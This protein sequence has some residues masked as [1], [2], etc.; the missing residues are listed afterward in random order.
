M[1]KL[2]AMAA[3]LCMFAAVGTLAACGNGEE[4]PADPT[5]YGVW[6]GSSDETHL[7]LTFVEGDEDFDVYCV[8]IGS[9]VS[10]QDGEE[11]GMTLCLGL[12]EGTTAGSYFIEELSMTIQ[13][14]EAEGTMTADDGRQKVTMTYSPLPAAAQTIEDGTYVLA[15]EDVG[16]YPTERIVFN[17]ATVTE[18]LDQ[19]FSSS[20]PESMEYTVRKIGAYTVLNYGGEFAEEGKMYGFALIKTQA[21]FN[22]AWG[23]AIMY[24]YVKTA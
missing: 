6:T 19:E 14:S 8:L 11:V 4:P 10:D 22:T 20:N 13:W 5:L 7:E 2:V 24:H 16:K 12:N 18:Y 15:E 21:G 9:S 1:K 3:A 23:G 17:G